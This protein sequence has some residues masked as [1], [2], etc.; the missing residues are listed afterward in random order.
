MDP[1]DVEK[2]IRKGDGSLG[3]YPNGSLICIENST[4][5]GGGACY[6]IKNI[7]SIAVGN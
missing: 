5:R 1:E 4:N 7:D 6:P 2:S 3:H